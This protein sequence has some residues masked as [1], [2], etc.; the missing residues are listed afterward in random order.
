MRWQAAQSVRNLWIEDARTMGSTVNANV[1]LLRI[2][3]PVTP[4]RLAQA[5][6]AVLAAHPALTSKFEERDGQLF[7]NLYE[8]QV[9]PEVTLHDLAPKDLR[10]ALLMARRLA[11]T[12]LAPRGDTLYRAAVLRV[13]PTLHLLMLSVSMLV[14]DGHSMGVLHRDLLSVLS[15]A[16]LSPRSNAGQVLRA[17]AAQPKQAE[18]DLAHWQRRLEA[19]PCRVSWPIA[20][21]RTA[22]A[23]PAAGSI[24]RLSLPGTAAL[25]RIATQQA[26]T[27]FAVATAA[28]ACVLHRLT[29]WAEVPLL[30]P[31]DGRRGESREVVGHFLRV[32]PTLV[33]IDPDQPFTAAVRS[34]TTALLESQRHACADLAHFSALPSAMI[35]QINAPLQPV[36]VDGLRITPLRLH[37]G[38]TKFDLS[39]LVPATGPFTLEATFRETLFPA[40]VRQALLAQIGALLSD[41]DGDAPLGRLEP[42]QTVGHGLISGPVPA[43]SPLCLPQAVIET[44]RRNGDAIA[45]EAGETRLSYLNVM[46]EMRDRASQL[47]AAGLRHAEPVLIAAERTTCSVLNFLGVL[48]AGGIAVP[49]NPEWP[50]ACIAGL[51]APL[52]AR[53]ALGQTPWPRGLGPPKEHTSAS[54]LAPLAPDD[55]AYG[56]FTSGSTGQPKLVINTQRALVRLAATGKD[57]GLGHNSRLAQFASLA[58]DAALWDLAAGLAQGATLV[59]LEDRLRHDI[60]A[61]QQALESLQIDLIKLPPSVLGRFDR[62]GPFP[63]VCIV[64]GEV[65]PPDLVH[66]IGAQTRLLNAYGPTEAGCWTSFGGL[67]P[68]RMQ[69]TTTG[70]PLPG[71]IVAIRAPGD[72]PPLPIGAWGEV[73]IAGDG[74]ALG[75]YGE[76]A[77][78]RRDFVVRHDPGAS[79]LER[80]WYRSGDRGRI[81][82]DGEIE[83]A[84][85][86]DR[87]VKIRGQRIHPEQVEN[88]L[89]QTL[90]QGAR[91]HVAAHPG[92][93]ARLVAFVELADGTDTGPLLAHLRATLPPALAYPE[94]HLV[95]EWP[96]TA[97]GKTDVQELRSR[98]APPEKAAETVH[99]YRLTYAPE[100][101]LPLSAAGRI[102]WR[103]EGDARGWVDVLPVDF[104]TDPIR[105]ETNSCVYLIGFD[106]LST[107]T[108]A[109]AILARAHALFNTTARQATGPRDAPTEIWVLTNG[110]FDI[111]EGDQILPEA[112]VALAWVKAAAVELPEVLVKLIDIGAPK[113][114]DWHIALGAMVGLP[115]GAV[116]A[117]RGKRVFA[118]RLV[119]TALPHW[120]DPPRGRVCLF[121]GGGGIAEALVKNMAEQFETVVFANRSAAPLGDL[122]CDLPGTKT[123]WLRCDVTQP[124]DLEHILKTVSKRHGKIDLVGLFAGQPVGNSVL[125]TSTDDLIGQFCLKAGT[126][127]RLC[128]LMDKYAPESALFCISSYASFSGGFGSFGYAFGNLAAEAAAARASRQIQV[129]ATGRWRDVGMT[130][131]LT[132]SGRIHPG[133]AKSLRTG[134]TPQL[135]ARALLCGLAERDGLL[136]LSA[137]PLATTEPN[138]AFLAEAQGASE[139]LNTIEQ[140]T[141]TGPFVAP[142]SALE[143]WVAQRFSEVLGISPVGRDDDFFTVG[144]DSLQAS[145]LAA[146]ISADFGQGLGLATVYRSARVCDLANELLRSCGNRDDLEALAAAMLHLRNVPEGALPG[147]GDG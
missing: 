90:P 76:N 109:D 16:R 84:G 94:I 48:A 17:A 132:E 38:T 95:H 113:D 46:H 108:K 133:F 69:A 77:R 107:D 110:L 58:V 121:L 146:R 78:T 50:P 20:R 106:A 123:L 62:A 49:I 111:D 102:D 140:K 10:H 80:R 24:Q 144:G 23:D 87:M 6:G 137:Y 19:H 100:G 41:P 52:G 8:A 143:G 74:L 60:P 136:Y 56:I 135:G 125:T 114:T 68:D 18:P 71:T 119:P 53:F 1:A 43:M 42:V 104:P 21:L 142:A 30:V 116:R 9:P 35:A 33:P 7:Q 3:G 75:Y 117:I 128:P 138:T 15:G 47:R 66:D 44:A 22:K 45:L 32:A 99:A 124:D 28:L 67:H 93:V 31:F 63:P 70:R 39:F 81:T 51:C 82:F 73:W 89:I 145:D 105:K 2:D 29:G 59:I 131:R 126:L 12:P 27:R 4:M 141:R 14:S 91:T 139:I 115:S 97:G 26:T 25:D 11:D 122:A 92:D 83:I 54:D 61:L 134:F 72:G 147:E 64:A 112:Q 118:R 101:Y 129:L 85:R 86:Y 40:K 88:A 127:E 79:G 103:L 120:S 65:C 37:N 57:A 34:S 130:F 5:L 36:T 98:L 55:P 96:L 13:E